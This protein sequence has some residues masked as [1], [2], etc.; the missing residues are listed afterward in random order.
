MLYK[1][2]VRPILFMLSPEAAHNFTIKMFSILKLTFPILKLF[3]QRKTSWE[4]V[5]VFNL[6][7]RNRLGIAAGLDKD[8]EAIW[9]FDAFGYSHIE[10]GTVTPLP[11]KGNEKPRLFRLK[12]DNALLNRMGFN[13][14]GAE[15]VK[16][17]I[18][19]A[20][21]YVSRDF[22]I[23]VNI[24]K[25]KN[26]PIENAADDYIKCLEVLYEV[27]DY[28]TINISSPNTEHLRELQNIAYLDNFLKVITR[29]NQE[30]SEL[31]SCNK[32]PIF[33]KIAPDLTDEEVERIYLFCFKY[34]ITGLVATNTTV[35]REG[36]STQVS[37]AGGLSGKPLESLSNK[38]LSKLNT[39]NI[40][41]AFGKLVL[42]GVGGV[43]D[44]EGYKAKLLNGA[45]LVQVYTGLIYEG[46][47]LIQ[48]ILR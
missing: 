36:L 48:K 3:V 8:G 4:Q 2:F 35:S 38:V 41:N 22:I 17:N 45:D 34:D 6:A 28:F 11:Q 7:F 39:L 16:K 32:K 20:R 21:Q 30:L 33:L 31:Y 40:S 1:T 44:K 10:V 37:E 14:K 13:N 23:G 24:G 19:K 42:I 12:K 26:T 47:C 29:K 15:Y 5:K 27:A 25:N 43:F 9:V 18:L 46:I